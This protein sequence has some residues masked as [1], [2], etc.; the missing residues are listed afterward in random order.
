MA[1]MKSR[2]LVKMG[3]TKGK[4]VKT[5][6]ANSKEAAA[7]GMDKKFIRK[8]IKHMI[9]D[10]QSF[11]GDPIF[12]PLA[13]ELMELNIVRTSYRPRTSPAPY[14]SWGHELDPAAVQQMEN[15]CSLPVSVCGAL[16]PD[17]HVGYGLPIGGVLACDNAVI[18]YAVGMDIACRMRLSV[19]DMPV[20]ALTIGQ[21]RLI[22]AIARE[23]RFGDGSAFATPHAHPVMD[24]NW[25]FSPVTKRFKERAREQL[26]TSGA[27]NHFV[28]FGI[29]RLEHPEL[30]LD[31][32]EYL[33]LLSHSGSR[34][35]GGEVATY[36]SRRAREMHPELPRELGHLA[37]L[38]M[39]HSLGR[40]Y[41]MAMELM[42]RYSKANH[43]LI[44]THILGNLGVSALA[45]VENHHN[46]AWKEEHR[47]RRLIVH[48]KG[49]TPAA[50]DILGVIP[51]SM[52]SPA[53]IVRGLGNPLSLNS[54][55]HGAGRCMSRKEAKRIFS[56][57]DIQ[58]IL[59]RHG[60]VLISAGRD[61]SPMAY[62]D[63]HSVMEDQKD[64]V[65][66][67]GLFYPK[68]VKMAEE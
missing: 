62:K 40:E 28:E 42:G 34:G 9:N 67:I 14:A 38:D 51:G 17:A 11:C 65:R 50:K 35:T 29:L 49:A 68:M 55:S 59:D 22:R 45:H 43:E 64:L 4:M 26:G 46:F 32:G 13:A 7:R 18:P 57:P 20:S 47:G 44:H 6:I 52:T 60:V 31:A 36:Y 61:E 41:W 24:E 53:Y 23:T 30:G 37:W 3:L 27:G 58:K 19:L 12:G 54:A 56:W 48:R 16:L 5:A 25:S 21:D 33:G 63:I 15:A 10:P 39:D 1:S 2:E 66:T 8:T